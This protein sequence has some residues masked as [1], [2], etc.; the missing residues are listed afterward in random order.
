MAQTFQLSGAGLTGLMVSGAHAAAVENLPDVVCL[1][2]QKPDPHQAAIRLEAHVNALK[3][4]P[5]PRVDYFTKAAVSIARMYLNNQLGDCVFAGHGHRVGVWSAND[6][7]SAGGQVIVGTDAEIRS[8]YLAVCGPGD[9]GCNIQTTLNYLQRTGI[10]LGGQRYKIRGYAR[11]DP[12]SKELWQ[13][14]IM[15][16]GAL[17]IGFNLPGS[18]MSSAVWDTSNAGRIVGGHDVAP[19]GYGPMPN[20]DGT[21]PPSVRGVETAKITA[22]TDEGVIL[23]SWGRLY[24]MTWAAATSGRYVDEAYLVVPETLWTGA[25]KMSPGGASLDQLLA[26]MDVL[27]NGGV[28]ELPEVKPPPDVDPDPPPVAGVSF[29]LPGGGLLTA[30]YKKKEVSYPADWTG[31]AKH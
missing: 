23:A 27:K 12:R 15:L 25:D 18:W 1:G 13:I 17:D 20:S 6:P 22:L 2:R 14:A 30:E 7:D 8:Q 29:L 10:L 3:V 4:T 24:L 16:G 31:R 5:P 9:N 11:F 26:A 28:P 21:L 19:C